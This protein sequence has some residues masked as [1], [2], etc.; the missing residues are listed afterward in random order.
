MNRARSGITG[1]DQS[2]CLL[3]PS[4]RFA[5]RRDAKRTDGAGDRIALDGTEVSV[6]HHLG[7]PEIDE[8]DV[9]PAHL[10]VHE[11]GG[12]VCQHR[13]GWWDPVR[14]NGVASAGARWE[15]RRLQQKGRGARD[16]F[17]LPFLLRCAAMRRL[18]LHLTRW[19][20]APP[21]VR[22]KAQRT[23]SL[24]APPQHC[25]APHDCWRAVGDCRWP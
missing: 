23:L 17:A 16:E 2:V 6:A 1:E 24:R 10:M 4:Q 13:T 5:M 11:D 12:D 7:Q 20:P 15:A 18:T 21:A 8:L 3:L 22:I 14:Q 25:V 9:E 19:N